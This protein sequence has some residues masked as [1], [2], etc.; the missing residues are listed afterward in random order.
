MEKHRRRRLYEVTAVF[1]GVSLAIVLT[2]TVYAHLW[3]GKY[4]GSADL[5]TVFT[6]TVDEEQTVMED[7]RMFGA[8]GS[9]VLLSL[10]IVLTRRYVPFIGSPR[11]EAKKTLGA[12]FFFNVTGIVF[13]VTVSD[14]FLDALYLTLVSLTGVVIVG[15]GGS[16]L[17]TDAGD[18]E[19][20]TVVDEADSPRCPQCGTTTA[21]SHPYC[22]ECGRELE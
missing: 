19:D 21:E 1:L 17:L 20:E 5:S 8:V 12:S 22:P 14:L 3:L 9:V 15:V 6:D 11:W 2:T 18:S 16:L 10:G 7:L 4:P 13:F